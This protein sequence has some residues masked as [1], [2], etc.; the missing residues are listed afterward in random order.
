MIEKIFKNI[1]YIGL[2]YLILDLLFLILTVVYHALALSGITPFS[3][4]FAV[5]AILVIVLN[6]VFAV[7][8]LVIKKK[9][10][11]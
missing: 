6:I 9:R 8:L 5:V 3:I 4:W 7:G 10:K 11:F 1:K 2:G